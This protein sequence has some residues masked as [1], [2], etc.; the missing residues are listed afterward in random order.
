MPN[1]IIRIH[2]L[3]TNEVVDREMTAV[4]FADWSAQKAIDDAKVNE[5]VKAEADKA[6]AKAKLEALGITGDDLK[7]LG[8]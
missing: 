5:I 3:E 6:K 4:E 7:A 1:P 2:N 8:L